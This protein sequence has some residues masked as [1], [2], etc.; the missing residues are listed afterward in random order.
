V[1]TIAD[2]SSSS[3]IVDR[4]K[5]IK[6]RV[7]SEPESVLHLKPDLVI[8][9]TFNRPELLDLLR[10]RNI[11]LLLLSDF[12]THKDIEGNIK[13]IGN[14]VGC[15][16]EAETMARTFLEKIAA[17]RSE[18]SKEKLESA[19]SWS[20]DLTVMAGDTLFD[21]LLSI[22][23][24]ENAATKVGLM[25]WPR[26]SGETLRK[27]NPDWIVIGCE[28]AKCDTV[29]KTILTDGTW[30]QLD[31]AKKRH[32]IRVPERALVSTSQFFG[33]SLQRSSP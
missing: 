17:L 14:A 25:H 29:E 16:K 32:F 23:H 18:H 6:A 33:V 11:P 21:D 12:S 27:W 8:A 9:A 15:S 20:S 4:I 31:A 24:L 10:K 26:I 1:S 13:K 28:A 2:E 3:H 19:V 30:K 22:N 7:H 5:D